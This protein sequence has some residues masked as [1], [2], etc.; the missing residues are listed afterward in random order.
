MEQI[1]IQVQCHSVYKA[2]EYPKSFI[3]NDIHY[4]VLEII[5]GCFEG[6]SRT[7]P[8]GINYYNVKTNLKVNLLLRHQLDDD[9]WHKVVW[10]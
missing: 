1:S 8:K 10:R 5:D 2:A 6:Y 3:W 4:N 9:R 7:G